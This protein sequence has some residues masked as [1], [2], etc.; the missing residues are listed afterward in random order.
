M[1]IVI[2]LA[3][4]QIALAGSKTPPTINPN[5]EL[6]QN[7]SFFQYVPNADGWMIGTGFIRTANVMGIGLFTHWVCY[8]VAPA[9]GAILNLYGTTNKSYYLYNYLNNKPGSCVSIPLQPSMQPNPW[10]WLSTSLA[11]YVGRGVADCGVTDTWSTALMSNMTAVSVCTG[12]GSVAYASQFTSRYF[13]G[14][15]VFVWRP[16]N[17]SMSLFSVPSICR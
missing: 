11:I 14:G 2:V 3:F 13:S 5:F 9:E 1:I 16:G 7:A 17:V 12:S 8:G 10:G 6:Y 15:N 4:I